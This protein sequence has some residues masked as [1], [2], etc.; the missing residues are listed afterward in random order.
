MHR[1]AVLQPAPERVE[2]L[3]SQGIGEKA[4]GEVCDAGPRQVPFRRLRIGLTMR[5]TVVSLPARKRQDRAG[6]ALAADT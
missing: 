2:G 4:G 1:R 5:R 3:A 6:R